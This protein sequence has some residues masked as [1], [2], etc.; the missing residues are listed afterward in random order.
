MATHVSV[1]WALPAVACRLVGAAGIVTVLAGGVV[2]FVVPEE[3]ELP[4]TPAQPAILRREIAANS[5]ARMAWA[6]GNWVIRLFSQV[7]QTG[8]GG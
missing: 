8:A 4:E 7:N 2:G 1:T 3:F 6:R 5:D